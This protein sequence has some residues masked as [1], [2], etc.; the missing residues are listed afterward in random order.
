[1]F[2]NKKSL[3]NDADADGDDESDDCVNSMFSARWY[4]ASLQ[5][6]RFGHFPFASDSAEDFAAADTE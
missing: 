1:L 4:F 3:F 2:L 5:R 6:P